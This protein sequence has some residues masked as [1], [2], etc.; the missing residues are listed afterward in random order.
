MERRA[1]LG[2]IGR[3]VAAALIVVASVLLSGCEERPAYVVEPDRAETPISYEDQDHAFT[4]VVHP[5]DSLSEIAERCDVSVATVEHLND[6]DDYKPIYPGQVLRVP[7]HPCAERAPERREAVRNDDVTTR[8]LPRP[9]RETLV[10]YE[11]PPPPRPDRANPDESRDA[12]TGHDDQQ[13][14]WSWWNKPAE[15]APADSASTHFIWPVQGR[16]IESFGRGSNGERNDGINIAAEEGAPIRAAGAGTVTYVGNELK[17]Y[18]NLVLIK[19]NNGYITAYAHAQSFRV[20]R[21][22][23]VEKGQIIG[24]AG[25]TGDVDRPQLHFEIRRGV[26]PIDPARFLVADRAS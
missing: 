19:H 17:G 11:P 25:S 3:G 20:A 16:V 24:T 7:S 5:G 13:P 6:L 22:D 10:R 8:P 23:I 21:G 4:V 2:E 14:W 18:G 9:H 26:Q 1:E 12:S 15:D